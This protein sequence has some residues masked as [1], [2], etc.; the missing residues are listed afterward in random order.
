MQDL[1]LVWCQGGD[2]DGD[3]FHE[4]DKKADTI[5]SHRLL[6]VETTAAQGQPVSRQLL[7]KACK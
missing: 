1:V 3:R 4:L 5:N 2:V 6:G 7:E